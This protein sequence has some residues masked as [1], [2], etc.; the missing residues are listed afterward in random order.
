[1]NDQ[2]IKIFLKRQTSKTNNRYYT[3]FVLVVLQ[4]LYAK[5]S[6]DFSLHWHQT[7][8]L[9]GQEHQNVQIKY[10]IQLGR[11]SVKINWYSM[12][13]HKCVLY[14]L[15]NIAYLNFCDMILKFKKNKGISHS[16]CKVLIMNLQLFPKDEVLSNDR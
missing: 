9:H 5:K 12:V 6:R 10:L 13:I 2:V 4:R 7:K 15:L 11:N 3:N 14:F 8:V 16:N 1:M